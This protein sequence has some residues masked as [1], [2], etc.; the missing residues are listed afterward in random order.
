MG[1]KCCVP[2]CSSGYASDDSINVSMHKFPNDEVRK[3]QWLRRI[4]RA[5][6]IPSNNSRVCSK[7]FVESDFKNERQ[8]SNVTRKRSRGGG[9]IVLRLLKDDVRPSVFPNQPSYLTTPEVHP[10]ATTSHF[11]NRILKQNA[12]IQDQI[13]EMEKLDSVSSLSDLHEKSTSHSFFP[14]NFFLRRS[15]DNSVCLFLSIDENMSPPKLQAS[16][17]V[18]EDLSFSAWNGD[19]MVS[20]DQLMSVMKF[21]KK[22]LRFSDLLNLMAFLQS[23]PDIDPVPSVIQILEKCIASESSSESRRKKLAF[24]CEQLSHLLMPSNRRQ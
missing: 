9:C 3:N 10:R 5:D 1:F 18:N 15:A 4:N 17:R 21:S 14:G 22:I 24:I 11:E 13:N 2:G 12:A 20:C 7:H 8:D 16:I 23:Q 19:G 6:F